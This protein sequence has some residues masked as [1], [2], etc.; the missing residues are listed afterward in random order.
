[1]QVSAV[2]P[3]SLHLLC[4]SAPAIPHH[5]LCQGMCMVMVRTL[6]SSQQVIG[7]D[8]AVCCCD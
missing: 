6:A 7:A 8:D 1:M 5:H 2:P 4:R 3:C